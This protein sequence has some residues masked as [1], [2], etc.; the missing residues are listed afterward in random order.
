MLAQNM[1]FWGTGVAWLVI[2]DSF[3]FGSGCDLR[4]VG[5]Y[6]PPSKQTS[7]LKKFLKECRDLYKLTFK[8]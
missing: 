1:V 5:S 8:K 3:E 6:P 7:V 4:V 2:S